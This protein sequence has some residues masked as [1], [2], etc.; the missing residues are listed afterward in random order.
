MPPK[1]PWQIS[2]EAWGI[3]L[4][5]FRYPPKPL[6]HYTSAEALLSIIST[7]RM[8]ATNLEYTNDPT[9]LKHGEKVVSDALDRA[10]SRCDNQFLCSWLEGFKHTTR[11]QLEQ[12]D[13][14]AISFC[15]DGDLLSQWRGYGALGGG[16]AMGWD[17]VSKYPE[18]FTPIGVTYNEQLQ[19]T[20]ADDIISSHVAQVDG[21]TEPVG[22]D[23]LERLK[24]AT[25]SLGVFF[26]LFLHGFKHPAFAAEDEFRWV[27]IAFNHALP[28]RY[29]LQFRK[30]G[31]IV[32]P[33]VEADFARAKLIEVIYGPTSDA[34]TPKWLRAALDAHGFGTARVTPS[35]VPMRAT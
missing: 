9:D 12:N 10:I 16:F 26:S 20:V 1:P 21:L 14:Y 28:K 25:G 4:R 2:P 32:K 7:K 3:W 35:R 22:P 5:T 27:L 17:P 23:E 34:L 13:Y 19:A 29:R 33:Y 24:T 15:T 18:L 31:P 30:F 11:Q 8:W 6:F